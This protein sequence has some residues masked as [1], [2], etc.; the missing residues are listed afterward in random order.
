MTRGQVRVGIVVRHYVMTE[1]RSRVQM[2]HFL[3]EI[4]E[5]NRYY[6]VGV[7]FSRWPFAHFL[8]RHVRAK[9]ERIP[10]SR[11]NHHLALGMTARRCPGASKPR[12]SHID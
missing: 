3:T 9:P 4:D 6:D 11:A 7:V 8:P 1:A 5:T 12:P 10:R 2:Q